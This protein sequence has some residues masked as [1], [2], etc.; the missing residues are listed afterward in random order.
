MQEFAQNPNYEHLYPHPRDIPK[1]IPWEENI[2]LLTFD[3]MRENSMRFHNEL[4]SCNLSSP[5]QECLQIVLHNFDSLIE[6]CHGVGLST[7]FFF[8]LMHRRRSSIIGIHYYSE[9]KSRVTKEM[10]LSL[11]EL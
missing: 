5:S 8:D 3:R 4:E 7:Q 6:T 10:T 1:D 11:F 9:V 2:S